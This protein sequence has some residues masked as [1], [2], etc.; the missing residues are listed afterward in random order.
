MPDRSAPLPPST[1]ERALARDRWLIGAALAV[2]VAL[3]WAYLLSLAQQMAGAAGASSLATMPDMPGM[4]GMPGMPAMPAQPPWTLSTFALTTLMWWAMMIGMMVPSAAPMVLLFGVV[5][6]RQPAGENPALRVAAFTLGY[7]ATWAAFS[8]LAAGAQWA[9]I[10]L[11]VLAPME[12]TATPW[13][14]AVIV[15]LAGV[16]QLTPLK[17]VCLRHCRSPAEFLSAH[18]RRGNLGA[19]RM[20]VEHG[21]YCVGCCWLLMALLFAVGVMNLLWVAVL[22]VFVL[23]E[24]VVPRGELVARASGAAMLAFAAYLALSAAS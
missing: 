5:Q 19:L 22:A 4:P 17:N 6:R 20:G 2:L 14:A 10:E 1:L 18:W 23:I 21:A 3:A 11:A 16:Y 12:L 15:A 24:K 7:L 8:V 9:L 13:L